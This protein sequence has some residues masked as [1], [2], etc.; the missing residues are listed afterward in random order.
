MTR[1]L[2][3]SS[4]FVP[5]GPGD[6]GIAVGC[7]LYGYHRLQTEVSTAARSVSPPGLPR[8]AFSPYQGRDFTSV[9]IDDAINTFI[10][11]IEANEFE[12]EDEMVSHAVDVLEGS[13]GRPRPVTT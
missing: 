6:E 2:G 11:W 1:E 12:T 3:F 9:E 4:C 5:P 7:A 13:S 10:P 8:V